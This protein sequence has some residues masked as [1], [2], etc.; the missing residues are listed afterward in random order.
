MRQLKKHLPSFGH[1][2]D[3]VVLTI[4]EVFG[5]NA[6]RVAVAEVHAFA[7]ILGDLG[8]KGDLGAAGFDAVFKGAKTADMRRMGEHAPRD[9]FK[10][11]PLFEEIIAAMVADGLNMVAVTDAN[12]F[13]MRRVNDQF[14]AIRQDRFKFIHAFAGGPKFVIHRRTAR[15]DGLKGFFFVGDV[16]LAGEVTGFVP[17][18]LGC[19]GEEAGEVLLR[20]DD[21]AKAKL[22]RLDH[23]AGAIDDF[24]DRGPFVADDHRIGDDCAEPMEE[25]QNLRSADAREQVFV[26]ARKADDFMGENRAND[27]DL[28]VF[29]DFAVDLDWDLHREK[30]LRELADFFSAECA[31]AFE[32][33]WVI[34]F[35]IEKLD[36]T[37]IFS[38]FFFRD[39]EPFA[40]RRLAHGLMS[41][42]GDEDVEGFCDFA[43]AGVYGFEHRPDRGR[44]CA[45]G[46]NEQ[47]GFVAEFGLEA[48]TDGDF[49]DRGVVEGA[50]F[51]GGGVEG[52]HDFDL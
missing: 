7:F 10:T 26:A 52:A 13:Q 20:I 18:F 38:P 39:F 43:D 47:D 31:Y 28:V 23:C 48:G 3:I 14:A 35:V 51:G 41:A 15:D 5:S 9:V 1:E 34:P 17:R 44:A 30:A 25:V 27:D 12:F 22:V 32:S 40:D 37:K 45:V 6:V 29:E 50:V 49:G 36:G 33:G 21:H 19:S 24:A 42:K 8:S 11:V 2:E 16:E 46:D 4:G